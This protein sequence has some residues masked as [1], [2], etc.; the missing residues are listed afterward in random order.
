[1]ERDRK[2]LQTFT[3]P[4][5]R[6][7]RWSQPAVSFGRTQG[8]DPQVEH[9]ILQKGIMV[10]GRPSGGGIVE[11][12][13]DLC[14]SL[15]W[16]KETTTIPWKVTDSYLAIHEWIWE[17]LQELGI[18]AEM[19]NK[20]DQDSGWC[21]QS[22]VCHDLTLAGKK[23]VGGAQWRERNR[24]LHQG[25]IQ[26]DLPTHAATVFQNHFEKKFGVCLRTGE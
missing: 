18:P 14:F 19:V 23:I 22:A 2:I 25:S 9:S 26:C 3:A 21:F 15:F 13:K 4:A 5:L 10:V 7:Y 11:H 1:M 24:A 20:K 8:I 12:G 6:F 17:A 16:N